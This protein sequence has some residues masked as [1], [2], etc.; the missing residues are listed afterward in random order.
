MLCKEIIFLLPL[1]E[2]VISFRGFC[3]D[4]FGEF[5]IMPF[6]KEERKRI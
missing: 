1:G 2:N 5:S 3:P 6:S 4:M